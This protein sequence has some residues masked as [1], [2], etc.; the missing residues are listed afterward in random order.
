MTP[1]QHN[2][3]GKKKNSKALWFKKKKNHLEEFLRNANFGPHSIL[4]SSESV[5]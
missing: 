4:N 3:K 2:N 5:G 1:H